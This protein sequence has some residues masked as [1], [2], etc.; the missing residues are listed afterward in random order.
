MCSSQ[1]INKSTYLLSFV[2]A[3]IDRGHEIRDN[4]QHEDA[5]VT[6][7]ERDCSR[8]YYSDDVTHPASPPPSGHET[9]ECQP[10]MFLEE[11]KQNGVRG[12]RPLWRSTQLDDLCV[13]EGRKS[14]RKRLQ[15]TPGRFTL[16]VNV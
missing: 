12:F 10:A 2:A 3:G 9:P 16:S 6:S 11:Q 15:T 14:A 13:T 5:E 7:S 4:K 8:C 1:S